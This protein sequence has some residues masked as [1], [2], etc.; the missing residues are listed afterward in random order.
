VFSDL[1]IRAMPGIK[2]V[3]N[4]GLYTD[5]MF[6][7]LTVKD[8]YLWSLRDFFGNAYRR[9]LTDL[10]TSLADEA[11]IVPAENKLY[12]NFPNPFNPSTRIRYQVRQK[13]FVSLKIY[14]ILGSEIATL[15]EEDKPQGAYEVNF[16]SAHF[17]SGIYF[18]SLRIGRTFVETK[19]MLLLR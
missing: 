10:L 1:L 5:W 3:L 11:V 8:S 13:G 18:Y 6:L 7:G 15:V 19:W 16:N 17:S 14:N 9:P 4:D 12:Q 2:S